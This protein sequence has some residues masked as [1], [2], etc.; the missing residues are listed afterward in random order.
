MAA[1]MTAEKREQFQMD[2]V[3]RAA[4]QLADYRFEQ[5]GRLT[6]VRKRDDSFYVMDEHGCSCPDWQYRCSTTGAKCKH[7]IAHGLWEMLKR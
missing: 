4:E 3:E 1:M 5:Q 6:V 7:Q 2:R